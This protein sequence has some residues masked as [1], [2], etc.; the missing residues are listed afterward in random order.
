MSIS[1]FQKG[2]DNAKC[3]RHFFMSFIWKFSYVKEQQRVF[4]VAV[5]VAFGAYLKSFRRFT[6]NAIRILHFLKTND[7]RTALRSTDNYARHIRKYTKSCVENVPLKNKTN[8]V[9][10]PV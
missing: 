8:L 7:E 6:T 9:K 5:R 2:V 4:S 1:D 10:S 3:F